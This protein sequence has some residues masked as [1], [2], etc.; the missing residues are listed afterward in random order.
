M[1]GSRRLG[2]FASGLAGMLALGACGG[3]SG[4]AGNTTISQQQ[5][6][7]V[8]TEAAN[9]ISDIAAGVAGF[10]FTGGSLGSGFFSRAAMSGR[11]SML[12]R[13]IPPR[14]RPQLAMLR[15]GGGQCDPTVV[16]DSTDSDGDGIE[17]NATFTF[18]NAN[19][20]YQDTLGNGFAVTGSVSIQDTDG[21]ATLFG[22]GLDLN[23]LKV[24]FYNDSASAGLDWDGTYIAD[25]RS[26]SVTTNRHFV[27]RFHVNNQVPYSFGDNWTLTFL[28]DTGTIDP[29]TQSTLPDGTFDVTGSY[30]WSGQLGNADGDWTFNV[31]TPTPLHFGTGCDGFDPPFDGGQILAS[32][33]GRSNIGFTADYSACGTPP[34]INTFDNTAAALR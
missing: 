14:Y 7:V 19:C 21:G 24:L 8:G 13:V 34:A 1:V 4:P 30:N 3:D 5:A 15:G 9:Q 28:P 17:N 33:N 18:T 16:G 27:T 6:G 25:V 29:A 22:F 12:D 26:T 2:L 11:M 23:H 20:F 32:I 31:S 10:S